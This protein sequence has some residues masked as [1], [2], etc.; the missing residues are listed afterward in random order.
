[1]HSA[2]TITMARGSNQRL[3]LVVLGVAWTASRVAT[4]II[5]EFAPAQYATPQCQ[6]SSGNSR[7]KGAARL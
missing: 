7:T 1:M 4:V 2:S 5:Y 6:D 3:A